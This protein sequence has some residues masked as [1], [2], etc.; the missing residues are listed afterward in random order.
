MKGNPVERRPD[1]TL[2]SRVDICC[3]TLSVLGRDSPD[4]GK[5]DTIV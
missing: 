5:P 2:A 1:P 3:G 4:D